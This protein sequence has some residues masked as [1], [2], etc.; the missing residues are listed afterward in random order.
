MILA[1]VDETGDT[2]DPALRG[3]SNCYGLGCVLIETDAWSDTF[4]AVLNLRRN[5]RARY[6]IGIRKELKA[7]YLIRG[8]AHLRPLNLSPND[9]HVIYRSHFRTLHQLAEPHGVRAFGVVIDKQS[10]AWTSSQDIFDRAWITLLQRLE[11]TST[12]RQTELLIVHDEGEDKR[13]MQAVRK[14]RQHL[15]A[16]LHWGPG[17]VVN[18]AKFFIEDAVPRSS[19]NSYFIQMADLV[20]YAAW[21]THQAPGPGAAAVCPQTTWKLLGASIHTVVTSVKPGLTLGVVVR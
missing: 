21:R 6:G 2:G 11:R 18:P 20:A 12:K 8:N 15:P 17:Y 14:A 3:S 1:Y 10:S 4:A 5:L 7:N 19:A 9:R 16:G 13:V